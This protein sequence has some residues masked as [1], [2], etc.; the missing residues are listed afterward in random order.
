[1]PVFSQSILVL[2]CAASRLALAAFSRVG[3]RIRLESH[4]A[5]ELALTGETGWPDAV[6]GA[7]GK[8]RAQVPAAGPVILVLPPHLLLTKLIRTPRIEP[9]KR[10][11]VIRFAAEQAIPFALSDVVWGYVAAAEHDLGLELLLTA[12]KLEV[13]EPLC[14]AVQAAGFEPRQVLPSPL[15]TLAAFRLVHA[16]PA[17]PVLV[18]NVGARSTTLLQVEQARF[19]ART[20]AVGGRSA[21]PPADALQFLTTRLTREITLSVLHFRRQNGTQDPVRVYLTGGGAQL[22][23]LVESLAA[24]L[25]LP[26]DRLDVLGVIETA[27]PIRNGEAPPG[28]SLADLAGAAATQLRPGQPMLDLLPPRLRLHRNW[29]RRRPWLAAAIV[30]AMGAFVPPF[31]HYRAVAAAAGGKV[32]ALERELAPWRERVSRQRAK[33]Q[34]LAELRQQVAQL[35]GIQ[36]RRT[37]WLNFLADLQQRLLGVGDVWLDQ[38]TPMSAPGSPL[39]LAVSGRMLD[40]TSP[41]A[42]VSPE[43]FNRVQVLLASIGDSPFLSHIEAEHFNNEQPG[44]LRFDF[45]LVVNPGRPL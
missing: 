8:L 17:E 15:A 34:Q 39:K 10:A 4:D 26:V 3:G 25:K 6:R 23:G 22:S 37:I 11:R 2:E 18:L 19:V 28:L 1:V 33:L 35:Q 45:V 5:V 36:D 30:L 21:I 14:A 31:L 44:V 7:L 24:E 9:A 41:L 20:L 12:A 40:R 16:V 38:L 42:R 13:V 27:R 32:D 43:T 29:R